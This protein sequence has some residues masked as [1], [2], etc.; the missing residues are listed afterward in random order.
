MRPAKVSIGLQQVYL[1]G[2]TSWQAIM[3]LLCRKSSVWSLALRPYYRC[4][5][6]LIRIY[7]YSIVDFLGFLLITVHSLIVFHQV[8]ILCLYSG[9]LKQ[10]RVALYSLLKV[11]LRGLL[12][13]LVQQ[14]L[15]TR[16]RSIVKQAWLNSCLGI[17]AF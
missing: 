1:Q 2:S 11:T 4:R 16:P 15:S 12:L 8:R 6:S 17:S 5:R 13:R 10:L 14:W 7:R 3:S 9:P